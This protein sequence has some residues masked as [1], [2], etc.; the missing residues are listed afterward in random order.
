MVGYTKG[1]LKLPG[2]ESLQRPTALH[3]FRLSDLCAGVDLLTAWQGT[4]DDVKGIDCLAKW[5]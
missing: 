3:P 5:H 4:S 1:P 2:M